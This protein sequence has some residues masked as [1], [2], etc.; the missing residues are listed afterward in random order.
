MITPNRANGQKL[1]V[2][3]TKPKGWCKRRRI[4]DSIFGTVER[5]IHINTIHFRGD[6]AH[7]IARLE[8]FLQLIDTV[9]PP[10]SEAETLR[11]RLRLS[12][13]MIAIRHCDYGLAIRYA[14]QVLLWAQQIAHRNDECCS[15][16][17]L[18]LAEQFAG[19]YPQAVVHSETRPGDC[20]G[21]RQRR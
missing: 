7:G 10:I 14:R 3:L 21:D 12:L 20:Q 11:F 19:L 8:E 5:R 16:I 6:F 9:V 4:W 17:E 15:L 13:P 18:A 2:T 1:I